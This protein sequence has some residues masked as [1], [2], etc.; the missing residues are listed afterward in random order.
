M[1]FFIILVFKLKILFLG[2]SWSKLLKNL[3]TNFFFENWKKN[4][5]VKKCWKCKKKY[6]EII[7][8]LYSHAFFDKKFSSINFFFWNWK[9]NS[10]DKFL[11]FCI[12]LVFK[13][14]I[15]FLGLS[16]SKLLKNLST[17]FFFENWKKNSMV[18][19]CWK[20][21]KKYQQMMGNLY[22]LAFFYKNI[23]I[24]KN[25]F[26]KQKKKIMDYFFFGFLSFSFF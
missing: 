16:W 1:F 9:K 11:F 17:K 18:K 10:M 4:Y 20:C 22:S 7:G 3:S 5:M 24:H 14:K 23:F 8:N 25:F 26:L 12:I 19:K 6:R 21:K 13:L 15:L 2:S